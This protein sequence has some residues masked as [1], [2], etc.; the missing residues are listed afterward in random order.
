LKILSLNRPS[1]LTIIL[2]L[3]TLQ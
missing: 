3:Y 2:R 1:K